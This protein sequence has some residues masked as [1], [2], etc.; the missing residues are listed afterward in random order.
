MNE[1][2]PR[3]EHPGGVFCKVVRDAWRKAFRLQNPFCGHLHVG[4]EPATYIHLFYAKQL[5][6]VIAPCYLAIQ[7]QPGGRR[8][9]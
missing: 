1:R 2:R 5:S 6:S 4:L 8:G 7:V 9:P 3:K